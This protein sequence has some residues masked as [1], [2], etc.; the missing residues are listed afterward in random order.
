MFF[1][2]TSSRSRATFRSLRKGAWTECLEPRR[3]LSFAHLDAT[4]GGGN[5]REPGD[6]RD[7][8]IPRG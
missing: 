1:N 3:M 2:G 6:Y 8:L 4:F 7:Q 5:G